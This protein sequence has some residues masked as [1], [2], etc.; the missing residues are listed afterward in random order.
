MTVE[1]K[2]EV[3]LTEQVDAQTRLDVHAAAFTTLNAHAIVNN[4]DWRGRTIIFNVT[5]AAPHEVVPLTNATRREA[6]KYAMCDVIVRP[7]R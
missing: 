6:S 4:Y 7:I 3:V 1:R 2:V 5:F